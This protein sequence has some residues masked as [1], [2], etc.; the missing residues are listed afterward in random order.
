M[1]ECTCVCIAIVCQSELFGPG[2]AYSVDVTLVQ[3]FWSFF[4]P[5]ASQTLYTLFFLFFLTKCVAYEYS[6][7]DN[8]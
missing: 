8:E 4:F 6:N 1:H 7:N 3:F 2:G 5:L